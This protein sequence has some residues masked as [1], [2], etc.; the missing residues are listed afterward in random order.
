MTTSSA[1]QSSLGAFLEEHYTSQGTPRTQEEA[2]SFE[3]V[4]NQSEAQSTAAAA[5]PQPSATPAESA[6]ER[7]NPVP[8]SVRLFQTGTPGP[9]LFP[10]PTSSETPTGKEDPGMSAVRDLM[11]SMGLD[12]ASVRMTYQK[13][14]SPSF[15]GVNTLEL[16]QVETRDGK[17]AEFSARLSEESPEVT[18]C[19]IRHMIEGT[20]GWGAETALS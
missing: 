10:V 1:T 4:L 15:D 5:Q 11:I 20:G 6:S 16:L 3:K 18:V 19:V 12:P 17:L 13:R 8:P 14:D 2:V 9:A 7:A